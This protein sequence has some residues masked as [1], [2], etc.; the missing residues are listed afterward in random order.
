MPQYHFTASYGNFINSFS[1]FGI[2]DGKT[3]NELDR[4]FTCILRNILSRSDCVRPSF[5]LREELEQLPAFNK[6]NR[7]GLIDKT[8]LL[9]RW[10]KTIKGSENGFNPALDFFY[11]DALWNKYLPGFVWVRHLIIP[12]A[13]KEAAN[14]NADD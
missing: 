12:E 7:F 13:P 6:E 10:D 3:T 2:P 1:I 9:P 11:D 8:A 14:E 5:F 4:S